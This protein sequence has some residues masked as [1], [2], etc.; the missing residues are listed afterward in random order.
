MYFFFFSFIR[1]HASL[2]LNKEV[3][4]EEEK[5]K[6][7]FSATSAQDVVCVCVYIYICKQKNRRRV[8]VSMQARSR[9]TG[10]TASARCSIRAAVFFFRRHLAN[11]EIGLFGSRVSAAVATTI[12]PANLVTPMNSIPRGKH[13]L[14]LS[15]L[16]FRFDTLVGRAFGSSL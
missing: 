14:L 12:G 7:T 4:L 6:G 2:R 13:L 9:G 16:F 3:D 8:H 10:R 15:F 11:A 5:Q 1:S